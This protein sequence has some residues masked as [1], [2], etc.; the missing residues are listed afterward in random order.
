MA[1]SKQKFSAITEDVI[2][3]LE[4]GYYNPQWHNTGDSRY[5]SSGET[6]FGIDRKNGGSI[7]TSAAGK[8][9][10]AIIDRYKTPQVWTW[11]YKGGSLAPKLK[12]LV[13]DMMYPLYNQLSNS[14][15]SAKSKELVESDDRLIF[16]FIYATWNGSG[17]F[18]K[19]ATDINDAVK[20]GIRNTDR[21]VDIAIASRTNEGLREGSSPNS[22]IKQGGL[23]IEKI[24]STLNDYINDN[25]P[26]QIL[27]IIAGLSLFAFSIYKLKNNK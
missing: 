8:E 17:W 6:M 9:F 18:K 23:K 25:P 7:N 11:N 3:Q 1:V 19:F 27:L 16:H 24:F 15:L 10:W 21:L 13:S 22:L 14:Y 12:G 5:G 4:G 20:K 26:A 2:E